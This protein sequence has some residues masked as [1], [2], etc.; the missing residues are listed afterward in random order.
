VLACLGCGDAPSSDGDSA[1]SGDTEA[2]TSD[3]AQTSA[4]PESEGSSDGDACP[5]D[6]DKTE[7]GACGC[8]TPDEDA[9]E[10]GT[11]DCDDACPSDPDKIDAG[12]CGCGTPD[13]DADED[14]VLGCED[15]CAQTANADQGDGDRDGVGEACDNCSGIPNADQ[16]DED[17]DGVGEA[18]A[19]GPTPIPCEDGS[20]AG[21]YPCEGIDLLARF[22]LEDFG[23]TVASDMWAWTDAETDRE[24]AL[25]GVDHGT[26]FIE[27]T[28]PYCPRHVG[29]LPTAS[30]NGFLRDIATYGDWAFVVA[31][32]NAHGMQVFDL[33]RLRDV[34]EPETFDADAQYDGFSNAHSLV[35][36]E[37]AGFAYATG[38]STCAGGL[39]G[40]DVR[41]PLMPAVA[42]CFPDAGYIHDAQCL[43]YAGPD[44]EHQGKEI[45]ITFDGSLGAIGVVDMTDKAMLVELS[46]T[47]YS[48]A[49]YAHQ[50]WLTEDHAYLLHNDEFD[51]VNAGHYT[52]TYIWDFR[53]LDAPEVIGTY[54]GMTNATDHNLYTHEGRLY[55][56]NYRSGVRVFDLADVADGM[57]TE[58]AWFDTDPTGDGPELMGAFTALPYFER[59]I[60]VVTDMQRGVFVLDVTR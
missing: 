19:C 4:A 59:D 60:V 52:R 46:R 35:I 21:L 57:L 20:A 18:C 5:S 25:V 16:L 3:A 37:D 24:Y 30:E 50:G 26:V 14:G 9:D 6:P 11:A 36:D 32:A 7:P 34:T 51:E 41:D 42:T 13:D 47:V 56:A 2:G 29:T 38:S 48:G 8:G 28:H 10:D 39:H 23:A 15:N 22:A 44:E 43:V 49:S 58:L 27:V 53:D 31:E 40:V 55:E 12:A 1:T 17:D 45:C 54:E 33:T